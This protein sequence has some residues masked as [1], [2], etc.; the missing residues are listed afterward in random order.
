MTFNYVPQ[1]AVI[2]VGRNGVSG[3]LFSKNFVLTGYFTQ[4]FFC[5]TTDLPKVE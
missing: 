5:L 3:A 2:E 4:V 1:H